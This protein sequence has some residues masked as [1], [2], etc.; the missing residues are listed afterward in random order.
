M[1]Q[2]F[3]K[4]EDILIFNEKNEAHNIISH[5]LTCMQRKKTKTTTAA[6]LYIPRFHLPAMSA[7]RNS[8]NDLTVF[9]C[10]PLKLK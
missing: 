8:K 5:K 6:H 1:L 2:F 9:S 7:T 10:S 4:I 3:R